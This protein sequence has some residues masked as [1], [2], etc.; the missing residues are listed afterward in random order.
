MQY[1]YELEIL[2]KLNYTHLLIKYAKFA[3]YN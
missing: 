3:Y 1:T 2:I